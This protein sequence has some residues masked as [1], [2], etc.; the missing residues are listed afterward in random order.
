MI[1]GDTSRVAQLSKHSASQ[2]RSERRKRMGYALV[3]V[4]L[5]PWTP[6]FDVSRS[7][8]VDLK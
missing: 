2:L 3:L 4:I 5:C 8:C 1:E 7:L 6:I